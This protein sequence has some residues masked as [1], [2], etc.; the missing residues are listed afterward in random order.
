VHFCKPDQLEEKGLIRPAEVVQET[1]ILKNGRVEMYWGACEL[2]ANRNLE[3]EPF[4]AV[5]RSGGAECV[6]RLCLQM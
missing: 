2:V 4:A 5:V 1:R 6:L 3:P